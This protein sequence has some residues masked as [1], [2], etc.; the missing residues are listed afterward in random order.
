MDPPRLVHST[1]SDHLTRSGV[2]TVY[3]KALIFIAFPSS[4]LNLACFFSFFYPFF[5]S[6]VGKACNAQAVF[7]AFRAY[8]RTHS[9]SS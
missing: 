1:K 9:A 3:S 5:L 7:T 6:L 8:D 4:R 2:M